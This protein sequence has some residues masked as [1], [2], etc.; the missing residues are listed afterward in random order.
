MKDEIT[1]MVAEFLKLDPSSL[2]GSTELGVDVPCDSIT[3]YELVVGLEERFGVAIL[4][5]DIPRMKT[6]QGI[7]EVISPVKSW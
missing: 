2:S 5:A 4:P 1:A 7:L 6:I 3:F